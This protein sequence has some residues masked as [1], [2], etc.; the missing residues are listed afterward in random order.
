MTDKFYENLQGKWAENGQKQVIPNAKEKIIVGL[1]YPDLRRSQP[2]ISSS[3]A[4][5]ILIAM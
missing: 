4:C 5:I 2:Q 1:R 3:H